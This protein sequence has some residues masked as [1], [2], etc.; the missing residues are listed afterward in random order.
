MKKTIT[1]SVILLSSLVLLLSCSKN[2]NDSFSRTPGMPD[3]IIDAKIGPGQTYTLS[4]VNTDNVSISKQAAHFLIS[5]TAVD[6]INGSFI[7]KYIPASGF[8]G[9]DEVLLTQRTEISTSSIN[10][11]NYGGDSR[12]IHT[13]SIAIKFTVAN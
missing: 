5:E 4:I 7:Y 10:S 1:Y 8:T 11:C 13:S 2:A 3:R 6:E 9:I 12:S